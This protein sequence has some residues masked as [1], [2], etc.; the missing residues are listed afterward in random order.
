[1]SGYSRLHTSHGQT[2]S[3]AASRLSCYVDLI[4]SNPDHVINRGAVQLTHHISFHRFVIW[5]LHF[6]FTLLL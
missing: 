5:M 4:P 3:W 1:M 6:T 2:F